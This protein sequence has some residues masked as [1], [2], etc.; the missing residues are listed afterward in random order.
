MRA[1]RRGE[2]L[3]GVGERARRAAL[4]C[5]WVIAGCRGYRQAANASGYRVGAGGGLPGV[6]GGERRAV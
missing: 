1:Q 4:P 5:W 2:E 6:K 3:Q